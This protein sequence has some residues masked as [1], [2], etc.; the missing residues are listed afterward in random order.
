[1]QFNNKNLKISIT[2]IK[3]VRP[4]NNP[5]SCNIKL[6]VNWDIEYS[7]QDVNTVKYECTLNT[8]GKMPI[9][10]AVQ[11]F[12]EFDEIDQRF[13]KNYND[14]SQLL[15]DNSMNALL[16]VINATNDTTINI[17]NIKSQYINEN[18]KITLI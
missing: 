8:T 17:N 12:V 13:G 10:F 4:K 7:K 16:N 6:D 11:G 3:M 5:H 18:S 1:M 9:A 2:K 15:L 14:F